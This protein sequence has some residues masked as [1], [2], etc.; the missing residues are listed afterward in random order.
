[1]T[2]D[3]ATTFL[4]IR[5][6]LTDSVGRAMM[7]RSPGIHLNA[8]GE[9]QARRLADRLRDVSVTAIVSS[10]LERTRET[11]APIAD[12]HHLPVRLVEEF[13][14]YEVGSWT[15]LT[16]DQ[17]E[18]D[19]LWRRFNTLRSM[20]RPPAG[21]LMVDV[22]RRAMG[23]LLNL[24][25]EYPD[26][27]VAVVSH[28]D[29][30]RG[31]LLYVLGMPIDFIHRIEVSPGSISIVAFEPGGPRV[32]QVNGDGMPAGAGRKSSS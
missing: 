27:R 18:T 26:G 13:A 1:M 17:L 23:A 11:A 25:R 21:E 31:V 9:E 3:S 7:G 2:T 19:P 32:L 24:S 4:L 6:G 22:Q 5:H 29:V 8:V 12:S 10:P 16:F 30:I 28:G 20:A 15:G 14:E